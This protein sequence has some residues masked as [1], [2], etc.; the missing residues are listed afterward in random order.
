MLRTVVELL[1]LTCA[2]V[3]SQRFR[4]ELGKRRKIVQEVIKL[5]GEASVDDAVVAAAAAALQKVLEEKGSLH[6]LYDFLCKR[7]GPAAAR[8]ASAGAGAAGA[9]ATGAGAAGAAGGADVS[10]A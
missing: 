1:L 10:D 8:A 5:R 6:K 9:G 4:T 3:C 2:L 7:D